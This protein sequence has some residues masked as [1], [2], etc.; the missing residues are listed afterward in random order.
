[1]TRRWLLSLSSWRGLVFSLSRRK[2]LEHEPYGGIV[3]EIA[4]RNHTAA[5]IPLLE[6][7]L[8][9]AGGLEW[10]DIEGLAV[11]NR[12]GLIGALI[13]GVITAKSLAQSLNLPLLGSKSFGRTSS[14]AVSA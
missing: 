9:Q 2:I 14:C 5:L 7:A 3:P 6:E 1:M 8:K 13:V 11:T 4:S 12:P 10:S